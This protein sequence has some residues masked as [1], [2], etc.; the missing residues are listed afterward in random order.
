[1]VD[2]MELCTKTHEAEEV[3]HCPSVIWIQMTSSSAA[4]EGVREVGC[5]EI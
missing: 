2:G 5:E 1:M 4:V 3:I